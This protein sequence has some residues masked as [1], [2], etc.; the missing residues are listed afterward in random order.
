MD[1][2]SITDLSIAIV[3]IIGSVSACMLVVQKSRCN[4]IK[5]CCMEIDRSVPEA[6]NNENENES[7][8]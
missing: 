1:T 4:K 7:N 5:C 6:I 3:S 2:Y 8:V